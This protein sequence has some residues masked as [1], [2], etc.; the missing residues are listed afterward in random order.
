MKKTALTLVGATLA[1]AAGASTLTADTG[2][3]SWTSIMETPSGMQI[4]IGDKIAEDVYVDGSI[5]EPGASEAIFMSHAPK[6][7]VR[8]AATRAADVAYVTIKLEGG[9]P[10][11]AKSVQFHIMDPDYV[12]DSGLIVDEVE[13][14]IPSTG[15]EIIVRCQSSPVMYYL[16]KFVDPRETDEVVFN[17]YTEAVN[18][19]GLRPVDN[20]GNEL[21]WSRGVKNGQMTFEG[22][23]LDSHIMPVIFNNK[24]GSVHYSA[25]FDWEQIYSYFERQDCYLGDILTNLTPEDTDYTIMLANQYLVKGQESPVSYTVNFTKDNWG[26]VSNTTDQFAYVAPKIE[27]TPANG[28]FVPYK[29]STENNLAVANY[30]QFILGWGGVDYPTNDYHCTLNGGDNQFLG[31]LSFSVIEGEKLTVLTPDI[32]VDGNNNVTAAFNPMSISLGRNFEFDSPFYYTPE[33]ALQPYGEGPTFMRIYNTM[34]RQGENA[35]F[36]GSF[37]YAA[38]GLLADRRSVC[39][40]TTLVTLKYNDEKIYTDEIPSTLNKKLDREWYKKNL[41]PGTLEYTFVDKNYKMGDIDGNVTT[42]MTINQKSEENSAPFVYGVIVKDAQ[43]NVGSMFPESS[44]EDITIYVSIAD[45]NY[46]LDTDDYTIDP[47]ADIF[48]QVAEHGTS[49]FEM[50]DTFEFNEIPSISYGY[51]YFAPMKDIFFKSESG[52]YDLQ[53]WATDRHGNKFSQIIS[54]AIYVNPDVSGVKAVVDN[55]GEVVGSQYYDLIGRPVNNPSEGV[56][57][58]IDTFSDGSTKTVK[59][60]VNK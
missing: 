36:W 11:G 12:E 50:L 25:W 40:S 41:A 59:T 46:R 53:I 37:S 29:F 44:Y 24:V 18:H 60:F 19:L 42:V 14:E 20:Q 4:L 17:F 27:H 26:L 13:V 34:Y 48:I 49:D 56:Y 5:M 43:G 33:H 55:R 52:Y 31:V 45:E 57:V 7:G 28:T 6:N 2:T 22:N 51:T 16:K 32:V 21:I 38:F 9:I 47:A 39:D 58:R 10:K 3:M 15:C 8:K 54:P 1:F 30:G 35:P 23:I